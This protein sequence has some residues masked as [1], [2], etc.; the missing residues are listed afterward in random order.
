[1]K[2]LPPGFNTNELEKECKIQVELGLVGRKGLKVKKWDAW[3]KKPNVMDIAFCEVCSKTISYKSNGKKV[4]R[5]HAEDVDYK[6][7]KDSK[8]KSGKIISFSS[9]VSLSSVRSGKWLYMNTVLLNY[10][11][12]DLLN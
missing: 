2:F 11:N 4:L 1:M 9:L 7:C 10:M 8:N 6:K 3:L 5:N 12:S